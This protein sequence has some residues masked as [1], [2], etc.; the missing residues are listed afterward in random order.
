M[1]GSVVWPVILSR[2]DAVKLTPPPPLPLR[3]LLPTDN[4][5]LL[6]TAPPHFLEST[7][8]SG[9]TAAVDRADNPPGTVLIPER[10]DDDGTDKGTGAVGGD[11]HIDEGKNHYSNCKNGIPQRY[12]LYYNSYLKV[13]QI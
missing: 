13:N 10:M 12:K 9:G 11:G 2:F 4:G 8:K 7:D 3:S 1:V 5:I 6:P